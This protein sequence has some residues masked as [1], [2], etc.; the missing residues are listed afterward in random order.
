MTLHDVDISRLKYTKQ[1]QLHCLLLGIDYCRLRVEALKLGEFAAHF[2]SLEHWKPA[3]KDVITKA[4]K[5]CDEILK[6]VDKDHIDNQKG[7]S[8]PVILKQAELLQNEGKRL[9]EAATAAKKAVEQ[10]VTA[11]LEAVVA[12]DGDLKRDLK[13]VK[14]KIIAGIGSVIQKLQVKELDSLVKKDLGT[15]KQRIEKLKTEVDEKSDDDSLVNKE[16][17]Q[18]RSAKE[19]LEK[20]THKDDG[21]KSIKTL[22]D[23]LDTNFK[24]QIQQPLSEAVS[25]VNEAI[26]KLGGKFKDH[27]NLMTLHKVFEHIK[28]KVAAIR[29]T[30]KKGRHNGSGLEGI[31]SGIKQ[32][33]I[34]IGNNVGRSSVNSW[35]MRILN[36]NVL[37]NAWIDEYVRNNNNK[38]QDSTVTAENQK[39]QKVKIVLQNTIQARFSSVVVN[40]KPKG[41]GNVAGTLAEIQTFH[42]AVSQKIKESLDPITKAQEIATQVKSEVINGGGNNNDGYLRGAIEATL[43]QLPVLVKNFDDELNTFAS[44]GNAGFAKLDDALKVTKDLDSQLGDAT[45]P[46]QRDP[47]GPNI[48]PAQVVDKRLGMVR[49]QV[50]LR[51]M[52]L[53]C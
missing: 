52:V 48:S 3:A 21:G 7:S 18:L 11:A 33:A 42:K 49:Q 35:V 27:G 24:T 40:E 53:W 46:S 36:A 1:A 23:E 13:S 15:L 22:T 25:A 47:S 45:N 30:P 39:I 17:K 2:P 50:R 9:L 32:Y 26:E 20:V 5:K 10:N 4:D 31:V 44:E 8:G 12:M 43:A 51:L 16:L 28:G 37:V 29:G 19:A 41:Q 38:F 6:R 34:N 14:E